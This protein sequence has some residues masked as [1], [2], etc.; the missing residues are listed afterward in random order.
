M[1]H[2]YQSFVLCGNFHKNMPSFAANKPRMFN[3]NVLIIGNY[4]DQQ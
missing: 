3:F 4:N 1:S 2:I